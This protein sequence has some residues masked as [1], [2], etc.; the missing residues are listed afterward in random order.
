M[1]VVTWD[2]GLLEREHCAISSV[3]CFFSHCLCLS[4][5]VAVSRSLPSL[6]LVLLTTP[7]FPVSLRW[8]QDELRT[9]VEGHITI[10]P[11]LSW[12]GFTRAFAN[13]SPEALQYCIRQAYVSTFPYVHVIRTR[14]EIEISLHNAVLRVRKALVSAYSPSYS[15]APVNHQHSCVSVGADAPGRRPRSHSQGSTRLRMLVSHPPSTATREETSILPTVPHS[16]T[17]SSSRTPAMSP[18]PPFTSDPTS[19]A[20]SVALD[21]A[22]ISAR[23]DQPNGPERDAM[24]HLASAEE[25]PACGSDASPS[26][27]DV[28]NLPAK[29]VQTGCPAE[30]LPLSTAALPRGLDSGDPAS[31]AMPR[32]P[33]TASETLGVAAA[34][35]G[36]PS[37]WP[38]V[39]AS[40]PVSD[41]GGSAM[42][43]MMISPPSR[44]ALGTAGLAADLGVPD[45]IS[46]SRARAATM[47][48]QS[49]TALSVSMLALAAAAGR[50]RQQWSAPAPVDN[51]SS[52][53]VPAV[54][55]SAMGSSPSADA[56]SIFANAPLSPSS[57][58]PSSAAS[59]PTPPSPSP[60]ML[61]ALADGEIAVLSLTGHGDH[62]GSSAGH[63]QA[64]DHHQ[65]LRPTLAQGRH[66]TEEDV[67]AEVLVED[68]NAL[69]TVDV[70]ASEDSSVHSEFTFDDVLAIMAPHRSSASRPPVHVVADPTMASISTARALPR[71]RRAP[72]ALRSDGPDASA[73]LTSISPV[74][75]QAGL[76]T[77]A[78]P[79][80]LGRSGSGSP[81]TPGRGTTAAGA[82]LGSGAGLEATHGPSRG[83]KQSQSRGTRS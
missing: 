54:V 82:G 60:D 40:R 6:G 5:S 58:F 53:R 43:R 70:F 16:P 18:I 25:R 34:L 48:G 44:T 8:V 45:T 32:S 56:V 12:R 55:S 77:S 21:A 33:P 57:T 49:R 2:R 26:T 63:G 83:H 50:D 61:P 72:Q 36:C 73:A 75:R 9:K 59:L 7:S 1:A 17:S 64:G 67:T 13:P 28:P 3:S 81:Q 42:M 4:V 23:S 51:V 65:S 74:S 30:T 35:A 52:M 20:S 78:Q 10:A 22:A 80:G 14:C 11:R 29:T 62:R 38:A 27:A 15:A 69:A 31:R 46:S 68:E 39:H 41:C 76:E 47:T 19:A 71:R 79:M 24:S 66:E 37:P